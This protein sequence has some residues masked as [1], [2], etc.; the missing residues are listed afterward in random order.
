MDAGSLH[1]AAFSGHKKSQLSIFCSW[2]F[3]KRS[4]GHIS[5]FMLGQLWHR[6][7]ERERDTKEK[8]VKKTTEEIAIEGDCFIATVT[9][10]CITLFIA[11][12]QKKKKE[13]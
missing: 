9:H 10:A 11:R 6:E 5:N 12:K 3:R 1:L 13:D 2:G 7:R 4:I 8:P